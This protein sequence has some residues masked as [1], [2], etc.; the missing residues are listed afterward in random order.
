MLREKTKQRK[1]IGIVGSGFAIL[2]TVGGETVP[3]RVN[4]L[5]YWPW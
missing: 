2:D 4:D 3:D 1:C 5:K